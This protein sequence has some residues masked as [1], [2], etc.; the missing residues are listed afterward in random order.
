MSNSYEQTISEQNPHWAGVAYTHSF[1]RSHEVHPLSSLELEEIQVIT[2]IRRS[3]KSTL[4]QTLINSLMKQTDPK[5]ILYI[6]FDD[7]KYTDTLA[8]AGSIY[9]IVTTAETMA[10]QPI[11]YLFLD[12]VQNVEN[13]ETYVKSVYDMKRFKKIFVTGSNSHLLNGDYAT[14]LSGRY[15]KTHIFPIAFHE[16]LQNSGIRE[17]HQLIKEKPTALAHVNRLLNFGGF[18]RIHCVNKDEQRLELLKS[19]YETILLKDCMANNAVRDTKMLMKLAHYLMTNPAA[20]YSYNSLSKILGS[21]EN[22]IQQ[23]IHILQSAY[24]VNE[25]KSF[26][27]SVGEQLRSKKKIYCVDNGLITATAFKFSDNYGK[28]FE[29]LVHSELQKTG[30]AEIYFFNDQ[31]ECDFIV[32]G[33]KKPIAIQACYQLT[34]ENRGRE[35]A[36][37]MTA[38]EKF[39]IPEGVIITYDDDEEKMAGNVKVVPFWKY[40]SLI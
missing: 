15:L 36:G 12:E 28:L 3:G 38:M 9:S 14:L 21:N 8:D 10:R 5:S 4:L 37:L 16:L 13:W 29:N 22:T 20:L 30:H 19:Y 35:I 25:L 17:Y 11:H 24:F 34:P 26:S 39:S 40:F 6:N 27:Y 33:P 18:P 23:F 2:G 1:K 31:K 7:P 32:H